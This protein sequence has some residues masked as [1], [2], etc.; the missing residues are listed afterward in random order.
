MPSTIW[1]TSARRCASNTSNSWPASSTELLPRPQGGAQ[2][3]Q[4][5]LVIALT[6]GGL[7]KADKALQL[8]IA[9]APVDLRQA[10]EQAGLDLGA[11]ALA[12][13]VQ[14]ALAEPPQGQR[15]EARRVG[16]AC[17]YPVT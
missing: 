15:S 8:V 14:R 16:K 9:Q 10:V 4:R 3:G 12:L 6:V 2:R 11:Q 13:A 1:S 7:G 5:G 17:S